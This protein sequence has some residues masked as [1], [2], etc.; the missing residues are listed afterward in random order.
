MMEKAGFA[1]PYPLAT[2]REKQYNKEKQ[3]KGSFSMKRNILAALLLAS[4]LLLTACSQVGWQ[5][6]D[7]ILRH[8]NNKGKIDSGWFQ[9]DS[10]TYYLNPEENGAAVS[11]WATIDGNRY[12]FNNACIMQTGWLEWNGSAYYLG[13]SGAMQTGWLETANGKMYL[14]DSGNPVTGWGLVDD[15]NCYFNGDGF[16]QTG[17]TIIDEKEYLLDENGCLQSGWIEADGVK[18]RL[19]DDGTVRTGWLEE[20]GKTYYLLAQGIPAVGKQMIDGKTCYFTS[21]GNQIILVNPWNPIDDD[22]QVDLVS[23][24]FGC[25][26]DRSCRDAVAAMLT[27]CQKAGCNPVMVSGYRSYWDQVSVLQKKANELGGY[28]RAKGI[29]ADPGT[30]EHHLGLAADITD[31]VNRKLDLG[32]ANNA[33]QKWLMEHCWDYGFILRYPQDSTQYTGIIYEP[34]H[35]RYVGVELSKELQ[36]LGI[37]LEEYLDNLTNDGTSCGGIDKG[38]RVGGAD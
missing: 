30:S 19:N 3:Q 23:S 8:Y 1:S 33:T 37:C 16:L 7:G 28:D 12:F 27:D 26:V 38:D 13:E 29:V 9:D 2:C 35:Y 15:R 21:T 22:Y 5:T 32:Q 31:S 17:I 24:G 4:A 34:W 14:S 36:E 25:M 6:K 18:H 10:G 11:G 20:D